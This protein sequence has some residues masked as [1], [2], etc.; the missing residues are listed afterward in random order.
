MLNGRKL[1]L[2]T[3]CEVYDLLT[4]WA[5]DEFWDLE[6]HEVAPNSIYLIGRQQV[7]TNVDKVRRMAESGDCLPILSNPHEGSDTLRWQIRMLG[8]ED[9]VLRKKMLLIGGGDMEPQYP[10][11]RYDT[12][13]VKIMEYVRNQQN[14]ERTDEIFAKPDKPYKFLF[15]NGVARPHRKYL[16]ERFGV[17]GL[18]DQA[19]WTCLDSKGFNHRSVSLIHEGEN[20]MLRPIDIKYL[21]AEYEVEEFQQRIDMP[22]TTNSTFVKFHLFDN[23]WGEIY[24]KPEQYIDTYFSLVTETI[25]DYPYSFRT[26]KIAKPLAMGHPWIAVTN[27]GYYKDIRNLGFKTFGHLIDESFDSIDDHQTRIDRIVQVVDDLCRQDLASFL[28]GAQAVCKYNQQHLLEIIP[29]IRSEFPNRFF[30]F[31]KENLQ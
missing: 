2:D 24:L 10:N 30:N 8:L 31:I 23:K 25:F 9:L 17:M 22:A 6:N 12:F 14:I 29:A 20:L 13:F 5:D 1:V 15:L 11:L 28:D 19:L 7:K 26:E 3:L 4:P 16:L 27:A 21:P 18:L